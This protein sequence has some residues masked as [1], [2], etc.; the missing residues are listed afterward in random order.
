MRSVVLAVAVVLSAS[1]TVSADT[2]HLEEGQDWK[3]VSAEGEDKFLL[4]VAEAKK[5]VNAGQTKAARKAFDALKRDFPEIAGPDLDIFI[6]AEL[7]FCKGK[8]TKAVRSYDKLLTEYPK[9]GLFE[10]ALDRQFAIATAYL[11]GRKKIVLGIINMKGYAEGIRIMEKIADRVGLDTQMGIEA[12]L[13][14]AQNYEE[15]EKF[16]E[17]YLKWWEISLQWETGPVGKDALLGMARCKHAVYNKNPEHRRPL[18]DASGLSTAKSCYERLRLLYPEDAEE[19]GVDEILKEI[20]DQL[21]Y[22]QLSIGRYYQAVG[23]RRSA[24]LY[25]DMVVSDWPDS[26]VAEMAKEMLTENHDIADSDQAPSEK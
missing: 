18:Y 9:S 12:S 3:A 21:A 24:N 1:S 25:Y 10:A 20:D 4:A 22:K 5:L 6:K 8:F 23:N 14:V 13:A 17:A 11:G 19:M 16:N 7:L 26:R 15:R 2:W